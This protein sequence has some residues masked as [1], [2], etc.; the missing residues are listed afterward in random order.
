VD[1]SSSSTSLGASV[2]TL[3]RTL[4]GYRVTRQIG[5]GSM[6]VVFEAEQQRL[7]RRVAIKVLPTSLALRTRTVKRFLREAA[8]MGRLSHENI[9]AV[10]EVGSIRD[11]HYFSMKYVEGPPLDRVLKAGPL[12]I[13]DVIQIGIDVARA[14][15]H[16]HAQGVMHRDI[17]PGN[18]L[19]DHD[20]VVLTD[21]GLARALD[22][23]E[24]GT[25]TESGDLVGTPL[26]MAP[27]QITG[28]VERIDGRTDVWGL[29]VTLY[30]LLLQRPPFSGTS[31]QGILNSILH[32][33]P[34]LLHKLRDDVPRDL[35]AVILKCLEKDPAR[36]Y[37]GAAA[38]QADLEAVR[39]G[40]QVSA[41]PPH[42]YDPALRWVRRHPFEASLFGSALIVAVLLGAAVQQRSRQLETTVQERDDATAARLEAK[43]ART[44]ARVRSELSE[45]RMQW[46]AGSAAGSEKVCLEA[47]QRVLDLLE[48]LDDPT[49]ANLY[50][51]AECTQVLAS[52]LHEKREDSRVLGI[53]DDA[54]LGADPRH[55]QV[56][57]AAALTGLGQYEPALELHLGLARQDSSAARPLLDAAGV[58]RLQ[59]LAADPDHPEQRAGSLT[60][61]LELHER[62]LELAVAAQDEPLVTTILIERA[63][64]LMD[65]DRPGEAIADLDEV[66]ERDIER[67]EAEALRLTAMRK[68]EE[69]GA[70]RGAPPV[71]PPSV[72]RGADG[73]RHPADPGPA[74]GEGPGLEELLPAAPALGR[75]DLENAG[76][77]LQSIYRGLYGL[78]R[79]AGTPETPPN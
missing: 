21:F 7:R 26:Y 61:A 66:L 13:S 68:Q 8:A 54:A 32:R 28:D 42:V 3:N 20:R 79:S 41:S 59:A 44:E 14:L 22:A 72:A 25:M 52:W 31:A 39:D 35:E 12:A 71:Q 65:L 60:Q 27:E 67:V 51:I 34:P 2:E 76:R 47:E 23:E 18:L 46:A 58:A 56:L 9:V 78:L 40:R 48:S 73:P 17:K 24:T 10:Y 1:E 37:S 62:A 33:D 19:R 70:E 49:G 15:A 30:E 45:A 77:G 11:L 53:L 29:G 74:A 57:Q 69:A 36:R 64:C 5:H 55:R 50:L 43:T 75:E 6:G 4:D 63:R 38:L 16:A